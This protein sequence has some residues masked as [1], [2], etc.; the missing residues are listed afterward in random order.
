MVN[1]WKIWDRNGGGE[2]ERIMSVVT[3]V[4]EENYNLSRR[5]GCFGSSQMDT[6]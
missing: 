3:G 4:N 6:S 5:N 1:C 2:F